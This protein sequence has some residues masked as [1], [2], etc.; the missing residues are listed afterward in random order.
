[1][2]TTVPVARRV[3]PFLLA[4]IMITLVLSLVSIYQGIDAYTQD[5]PENGSLFLTM[6]VTTLAI[7]T[8]LLFQT[9]KRVLKLG[10]EMPPLT[11]TLE[12]QKCGFKNVRDFQRGDYIFKQL[13]EQ[14]PKCNEKAMSIGS[15]FR[16]IKEKEKTKEPRYS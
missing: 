16:E 10:M 9:K 4:I 15:I 3:S 14:C 12:C 11:T 6:G 5:K 8:Y 7:S 1:M 13:E 2:E